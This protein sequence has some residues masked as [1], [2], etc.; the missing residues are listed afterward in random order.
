M[1]PSELVVV[2][3][4]GCPHCGALLETL[5]PLTPNSQCNC[6]ACTRLF[7]STEAD[8][9]PLQP[10]PF[11]PD[12]SQGFGRGVTVDRVLM[13]AIGL[14][15]SHVSAL[16]ITS[17][18]VNS[19]WFAV[20]GLPADLLIGQWRSALAGQSTELGSFVVIIL[21]TFGLV[22]LMVP[23]SAY[24]M[25]VMVRLSLQICRYG[26]SRPLTIGAALSHWHVPFR[27]L[28]QVSALFIA[29]GG[30]LAAIVLSGIVVIVGLS[31]I[32]D[33]QSAT[34][35]GTLGMGTILIGG[36]FAM[37]WLLWPGLFL[38]ADE[39]ANLLTAVCWG[40]RVAREHRK[41]TL[42]LVTVYFLLATLGKLIFYVG[43]VVTAP[44]AIVPM[45][46]GYLR[47]T[48]GESRR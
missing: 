30:M 13:P 3:R 9:P 48:G 29:V 7:L 16:L 39:R 21:A 38:I 1:D 40:V 31:L 47:M 37:Q 43:E 19:L 12:V 45:A 6:G 17:L 15:K 20:V 34:L 22:L 4:L 18:F 10:A 8:V 46:L 33:P 5:T 24:A 25:V 36:V 14:L 11:S 26:M 44:M 2:P 42:S 32:V 41:L 27:V 23:M 28:G 35:I